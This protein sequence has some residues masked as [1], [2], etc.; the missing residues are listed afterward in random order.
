MKDLKIDFDNRTI[1]MTRKFAELASDPFTKEFAKLQEARTA[2]PE[3]K[4][5]R[6]TIRKNPNKECYKGLT[7][8]YM[9]EYIKSHEPKVKC[10]KVLATLEEKIY[11]TKCHSNCHRYPTV[12]KWFLERYPYVATFGT[13]NDK[14]ETRE[15]IET[16]TTK[17]EQV[18]VA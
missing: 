5:V 16:Q 17:A 2:Y 9:R 6:H 11:I 4:V 10:E 14:A 1:V 13:A 8:D 12:K 3:Y 7:Y 15:Q 18:A